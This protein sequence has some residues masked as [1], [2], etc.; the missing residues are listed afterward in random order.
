MNIVTGHPPNFDDIVAVFPDAANPNVVFTYGDS[1]YVPSGKPLI[2]P[3]QAHEMIHSMRQVRAEGGAKTW[4]DK[5]LVDTEFRLVEELAGHCAEYRAF[6]TMVK[7]RNEV[8][9]Y[10]QLVANKLAAPLYGNLI[11]PAQARRLLTK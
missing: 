5:Y 6:S 11:S 3:I 10:L 1:V 9:R 7:D 2:A 8:A 4:W